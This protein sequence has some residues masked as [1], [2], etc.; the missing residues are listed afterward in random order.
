MHDIYEH[1]E[2][3]YT[4]VERTLFHDLG[5][6]GYLNTYDLDPMAAYREA[7]LKCFLQDHQGPAVDRLRQGYKALVECRVYRHTPEFHALI[8]RSKDA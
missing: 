3:D 1:S 4:E 7:A 8:E 2:S 6:P 5:L